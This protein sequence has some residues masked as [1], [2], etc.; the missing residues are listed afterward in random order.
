MIE[1]RGIRTMTSR[2]ATLPVLIR[3]WR[4]LAANAFS[5]SGLENA[6]LGVMGGFADFH[7]Q[8]NAG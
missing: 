4:S 7:K 2:E 5:K 6:G 3:S 1:P 8:I